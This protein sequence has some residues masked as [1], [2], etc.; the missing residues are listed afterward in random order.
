MFRRASRLFSCCLCPFRARLL[1]SHS[2]RVSSG[3]TARFAPPLSL[4]EPQGSSRPTSVPFGAQS[5][6]GCPRRV[7]P[8]QRLVYHHCHVFSSPI[9]HH[10]VSS[11][12][13]AYFALQLPLSTLIARRLPPPC[14]VESHGSFNAAPRARSLDSRLS[15]FFFAFFPIARRS[16]PSCFGSYPQH[17]CSM[18]THAVFLEAPRFGSARLHPLSTSIAQRLPL[19]C[20]FRRRRPCVEPDCSTA[21]HAVF[22]FFDIATPFSSLIARQPLSS[23]TALSSLLPC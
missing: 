2:C 4:V 9:A 16:P 15:R 13:T 20:F 1:N 8:A 19:P 12:P 21:T 3:S 18:A 11:S 5:H 14:F 10:S 23:V 17:D 22:F 6:D 7:S